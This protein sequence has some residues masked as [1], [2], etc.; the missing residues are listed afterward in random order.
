VST[1]QN[2]NSL[3]LAVIEE[4]VRRYDFSFVLKT[5][6]DAFV[7]V[8]ALVNDV[9]NRCLSRD[10][11]Q[12]R[13]YMGY[14]VGPAAVWHSLAAL[15]GTWS[16]ARQRAWPRCRGARAQLRRL[17]T[18]ADEPSPDGKRLRQPSTCPA[19]RACSA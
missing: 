10:C 19:T 15:N 4:V 2:I 6:D 16:E 9:R 1:Y 3:S 8:P 11:T 18:R 5:D 13:L 17:A 14:Q 7:N 12:E